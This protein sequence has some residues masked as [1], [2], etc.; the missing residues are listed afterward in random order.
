MACLWEGEEPQENQWLSKCSGCPRRDKQHWGNKKGSRLPSSQLQLL[1]P[2][3]GRSL[4]ST[5][6]LGCKLKA[7]HT[8]GATSRHSPSRLPSACPCVSCACHTCACL[9]LERQRPWWQSLPLIPLRLSA[10]QSS[11]T[12]LTE[13][14]LNGRWL[15]KGR[16]ESK[17]KD[18]MKERK[19]VLV[20]II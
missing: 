16:R 15:N 12:L 13:H 9:L 6:L 19:Q 10:P 5:T 18:G 3:P 4:P 1:P 2:L 17:E 11:T 20:V 7:T 8:T 14:T